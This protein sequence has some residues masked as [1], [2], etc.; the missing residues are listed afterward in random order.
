MTGGTG[1]SIE[2]CLFAENS[3]DQLGDGIFLNTGATIF[4]C[5]VVDN[6]DE[7]LR[8]GGGTVTVYNSIL[9]GHDIDVVGSVSLAWSNVGSHS[10]ATLTNS[11]SADPLF[12]AP[13][14]DNYRLA[15]ESPCINAGLNQDWMFDA[16]DLDGNRRIM[17]GR[18][19]MGAY[20]AIPPS[21][22]MIILR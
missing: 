7:G 15:D 20:E 2:N 10:G 21:G 12:I 4:N 11:I 9:W 8:R 6:A 17:G 1:H 3:S 5:T 18:V 13:G 14:E 19:D 16:T 22:T